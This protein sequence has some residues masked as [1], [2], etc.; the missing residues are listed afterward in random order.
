[1][2]DPSNKDLSQTKCEAGLREKT[3][4]PSE[5]IKTGII[6]SLLLN[7]NSRAEQWKEIITPHLGHVTIGWE[8]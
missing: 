7:G 1:M 8:L 5:I 2:I 3:P 4:T 6:F